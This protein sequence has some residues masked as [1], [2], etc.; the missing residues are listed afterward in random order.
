MCVLKEIEAAQ[1]F[2]HSWLARSLVG[3]RLGW[4]CI[5][6]KVGDRTS[7][8]AWP[9]HIPSGPIVLQITNMAR[10]M[11]EQELNSSEGWQD[12]TW[13]LIRNRTRNGEWNSFAQSHPQYGHRCLP[14]SPRSH[15]IWLICHVCHVADLWERWVNRLYQI[16]LGYLFN[17]IV[18]A[19]SHQA[20]LELFMQTLELLLLHFSSF[21]QVWTMPFKLWQRQMIT[22][23]HLKVWVSVLLQGDCSVVH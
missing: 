5:G 12:G 15:G 11:F 4:L 14:G 3:G 7:T 6:F 16:G 17:K 8:S 10:I 20:W 19:G 1:S 2:P 18:R 13:W 21:G 9:F 23:R 22:P